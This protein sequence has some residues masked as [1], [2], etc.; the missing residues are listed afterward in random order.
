MHYKLACVPE[1]TVYHVGGGTL[2]K[3][4]PH[5]TYLN[6]RNGLSLLYKNLPKRHFWKIFI[7]MVLDGLA[8]VKFGLENDFAHTSAVFRAH[9][10]FYGQLR[11]NTRK[12]KETNR[13]DIPGQLKH[14]RFLAWHYFGAGKKTFKW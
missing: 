1:S 14:I 2:A 8:A 9:M 12:R 7:R 6:F 13:R 5:K 3:T 11:S 10:H 4:N